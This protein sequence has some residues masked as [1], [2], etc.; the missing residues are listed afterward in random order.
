M[1][2]V[3]LVAGLIGFITY[4]L[5]AIINKNFDF[6]DVCVGL[7]VGM[8]VM[9]ALF[10]VLILFG[11]INQAISTPIEDIIYIDADIT[12]LEDN[13]QIKGRK[14]LTHGYIDETLSYTY[15]NKQ[16]DGGYK[17]Y[18]VPA[19]DSTVYYIKDNEQPHI[20]YHK[21]QF[22]NPVLKF[23]YNDTPLFDQTYKIYVPEG[24]IVETYSIDLR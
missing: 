24:T 20:E 5:I 7:L 9:I 2:I 14:Y 13:F 19:S 12:T 18:S 8:G 22:V 16:I 10:I 3:S 1:K 11:V 4:I 17:V 21:T 6:G 23:L 15:I